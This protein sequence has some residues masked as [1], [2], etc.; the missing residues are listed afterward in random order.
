MTPSPLDTR[1]LWLHLATTPP[2]S[3]DGT[4]HAWS[5]AIGIEYVTIEAQER[6]GVP[7][8]EPA[9]C[10]YVDT[11]GQFVLGRTWSISLVSPNPANVC[12][13]CAAAVSG[14][15]YGKARIEIAEAYASGKFTVPVSSCR[16]CPF[17]GKS[18]ISIMASKS[19]HAGNC[20]A[21]GPKLGG[22]ILLGKTLPVEDSRVMPKWC[23]LRIGDITVTATT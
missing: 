19:E 2:G 17:F 22:G 7:P 9:L 15:P 12:P 10:G 14:L 18:L 4:W 8:S 23:P 13:A 3:Q 5:H 20:R 11:I 21:P 1:P 6:N 16:D